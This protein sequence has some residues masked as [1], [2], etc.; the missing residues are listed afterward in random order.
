VCGISRL[1]RASLVAT[2]TFIAAGAATVAVANHF[3]L[4]AAVTR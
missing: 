1:A 3:S 4:F 2:A